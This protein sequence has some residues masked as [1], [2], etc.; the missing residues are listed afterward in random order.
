M[1]VVVFLIYS[2]W[3][4]SLLSKMSRWL[5]LL[6]LVTPIVFQ[7]TA[8]GELELKGRYVLEQPH[9][10]GCLAL[11]VQYTKGTALTN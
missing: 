1:C 7:M 5:I 9:P 2:A 11:H 6:L 10:D 8:N 3:E 4:V